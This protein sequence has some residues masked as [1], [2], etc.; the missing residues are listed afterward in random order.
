MDADEQFEQPVIS[1]GLPFNEN[2]S[3]GPSPSN[4]ALGRI[5]KP[6]FKI[7]SITY[8]STL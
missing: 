5:K 6:L 2:P 3:C 1:N 8:Q 7:K 4:V